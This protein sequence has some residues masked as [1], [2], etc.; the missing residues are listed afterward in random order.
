MSD[1]KWE[2]MPVEQRLAVDRRAL[3]AAFDSIA[4]DIDDAEERG[5]TGALLQA[6]LAA[7][8]VYEQAEKEWLTQEKRHGLYPAIDALL[9]T[10]ITLDGIQPEQV[11]GLPT[12]AGQRVLAVHAV[13]SVLDR[14]DDVRSI[15]E[16][17][18]SQYGWS[19]EAAAA[20]QK[21]FIV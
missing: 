8:K 3:R 1:D 19:V 17:W 7:M 21:E 10:L 9:A 13:L 2:A 12:I 4:I 18:P 11:E 16:E 15:F 5:I 20:A 6:A 14:M